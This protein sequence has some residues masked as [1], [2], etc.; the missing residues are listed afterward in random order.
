MCH[1]NTCMRQDKIFWQAEQED[2]YH[3]FLSSLP[4]LWLGEEY[5]TFFQLVVPSLKYQL[6]ILFTCQ[7]CLS[8]L[9]YLTASKQRGGSCG[10]TVHRGGRTQQLSNHSP[11]TRQ[12]HSKVE[13]KVA[14]TKVLGKYFWRQSYLSTKTKAF[15]RH[16]ADK[17]LSHQLGFVP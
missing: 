14:K 7:D 4:S 15:T 6:S 12:R 9:L 3:P 2:E 8:N 5:K 11:M 16:L 13:N 17:I 10:Y 1:V